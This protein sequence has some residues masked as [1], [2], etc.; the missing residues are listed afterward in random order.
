MF[1]TSECHV[2]YITFYSFIE[3]KQVF[4]HVLMTLSFA[5]IGPL[6]LLVQLVLREQL[7]PLQ[8]LKKITMELDEVL[9][10]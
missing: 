6:L 1:K 2:L 9:M 4:P 8:L 10:P 5:L 7:V 3:T